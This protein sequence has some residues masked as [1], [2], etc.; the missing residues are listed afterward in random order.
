AWS[1][2]GAGVR[3]P[4]SCTPC[5]RSTGTTA[6]PRRCRPGADRSSVR[7]VPGVLV[8]VRGT[9]RSSLR[10]ETRRL[11]ERMGDPGDV[12]TRIDA[13]VGQDARGEDGLWL[14]QAGNG[15]LLSLEVADRAHA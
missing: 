10:E 3:S 11:G 7:A 6:G 13:H 14:P 1:L 8:G 15:D 12:R 4:G 9:R 5:S 2:P